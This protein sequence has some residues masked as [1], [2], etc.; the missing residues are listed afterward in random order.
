MSLAA[1]HLQLASMW[2]VVGHACE[3]CMPA[4]NPLYCSMVSRQAAAVARVVPRQAAW[5][6][7]CVAPC[8][9][10][11]P[12]RLTRVMM[13]AAQVRL[14]WDETVPV[15]MFNSSFILLVFTACLS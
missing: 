13:L 11:C 2:Q 4:R 10:T 12:V 14:R 3:G 7:I 15:M 9:S 1:I 5:C 8:M 6:L